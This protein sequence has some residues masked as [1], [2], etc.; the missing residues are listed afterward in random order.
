MDKV[1]ELMDQ[2]M[3]KVRSIVKEFSHTDHYMVL[4]V[5]RKHGFFS[6]VAAII[7]LDLEARV[8]Q[9]TQEI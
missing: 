1:K 4:E 3:E 6:D 9:L 2:F 5:L 7:S 8:V